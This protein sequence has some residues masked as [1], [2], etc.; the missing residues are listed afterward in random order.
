MMAPEVSA[1]SAFVYVAGVTAFRVSTMEVDLTDRESVTFLAASLGIISLAVRWPYDPEVVVTGWG[2]LDAEAAGPMLAW[3]IV[4]L[5]V[6]LCSL[7]NYCLVRGRYGYPRD[8][9][10]KVFFPV[11]H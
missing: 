7:A 5:A 11:D 3:G 6:G 1:W 8:A 10:L 9:V 4:G 2:L